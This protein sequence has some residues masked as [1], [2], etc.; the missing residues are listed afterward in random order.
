[1]GFTTRNF[2]L[3]NIKENYQVLKRLLG[4]PDYD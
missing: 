1:M 2:L 4:I 3:E